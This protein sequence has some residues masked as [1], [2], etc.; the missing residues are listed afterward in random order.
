MLDKDFLSTP[1]GI[2]KQAHVP[3]PY[4]S[5]HTKWDTSRDYKANYATRLSGETTPPT[6]NRLVLLPEPG[7]VEFA[8]V[9]LRF[10]EV[11]RDF[12]PEKLG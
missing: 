3:Q 11:T 2:H 8:V 12:V 4:T 10:R 1:F 5:L 9:C 7:T 6:V